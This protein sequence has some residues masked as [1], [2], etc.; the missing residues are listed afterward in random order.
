MRRWRERL[1]FRPQSR[2]LCARCGRTTPT[3]AAME[4]YPFAPAG[5]LSHG[6][7]SAL[8]AGRSGWVV[9][10]PAWVLARAS[11]SR[12]RR[13]GGGGARGSRQPRPMTTAEFPPQTY[14]RRGGASSKRGASGALVGRSKSTPIACGSP[15]AS[16]DRPPCS[17]R[18]RTRAIC[19]VEECCDAG[20]PG[21]AV[22]GTENQVTRESYRTCDMCSPGAP[23]GYSRGPLRASKLCKSRRALVADLSQSCHLS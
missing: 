16:K 2:S 11:P 21:E 10:S 3:A 8:R 17:R 12:G 23:K 9:T 4:R 5:R 22:C 1:V 19:H 6:A 15:P 7:A 20:A 14:P 13:V 18:E